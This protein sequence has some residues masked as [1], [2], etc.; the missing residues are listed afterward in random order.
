MCC[1]RRIEAAGEEKECVP[2]KV[3]GDV[4]FNKPMA[5]DAMQTPYDRLKVH[6]ATGNLRQPPQ[7]WRAEL[8]N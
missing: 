4:V 3:M 7:G 8:R 5:S 6:R 2:R 1:R